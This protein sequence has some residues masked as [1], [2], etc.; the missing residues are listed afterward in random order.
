MLDAASCIYRGLFV[1]TENAGGKFVTKPFSTFL[2][3]HEK[4]NNYQSAKHHQNAMIKAD[5]LLKPFGNPFQSNE[6]QF[7]ESKL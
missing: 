3:I 2:K 7:S 6:N 1:S 4:A 5:K